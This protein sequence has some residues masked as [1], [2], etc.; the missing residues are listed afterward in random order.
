MVIQIRTYAE[1]ERY[2]QGQ[3]QK[4]QLYDANTFY[5]SALE[6]K[7]AIST[8]EGHAQRWPP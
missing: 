2:V 6:A 8:T 1:L 7:Q 4:G 3:L 5:Q